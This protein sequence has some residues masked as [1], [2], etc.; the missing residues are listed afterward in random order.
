MVEGAT[1]LH[2]NQLY[3][4][5]QPKADPMTD[6]VKTWLDEWIAAKVVATPHL[7][8][9]RQATEVYAPALRAEAMRI[10]ITRRELEK[11]A[12]GDLIAYLENAIEDKMD[13]E[14]WKN[15][16]PA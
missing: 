13:I 4:P 16:P 5:H 9:K 3:S 14:V 12:A 1:A 7:Q 8:Q 10:G 15:R 2:N 11:A 6:R